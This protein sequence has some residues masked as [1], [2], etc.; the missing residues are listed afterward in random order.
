MLAITNSLRVLRRSAFPKESG[1]KNGRFCKEPCKFE[2]PFLIL[3]KL[4]EGYFHF[5]LAFQPRLESRL[6]GIVV[7]C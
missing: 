6:V 2:E 5:V 3:Q 7:F 4:F 1:P